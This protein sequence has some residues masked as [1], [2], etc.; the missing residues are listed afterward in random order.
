[1]RI[2]NHTDGKSIHFDSYGAVGVG[3]DPV[4]FVGAAVFV[5]GF[6]DD[7]WLGGGCV[8]YDDFFGAGSGALLMS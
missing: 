1:M 3:D 4:A 2:E 7:F 8:L 5:V 6:V